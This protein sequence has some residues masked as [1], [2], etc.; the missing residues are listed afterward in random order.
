MRDLADRR[1]GRLILVTS[2]N[3]FHEDTQIEPVTVDRRQRAALLASGGTAEALA[4][5]ESTN[6]A[7]NIWDSAGTTRLRDPK[8]YT[9][10]NTY[11]TQGLVYEAY[12]DLYL[13]I[14]RNAT[15]IPIFKESFESFQQ[16][17]T[18]AITLNENA[19]VS[20]TPNPGNGGKKSLELRL[21]TAAPHPRMSI[22]VEGAHVY[23][24]LIIDFKFYPQGTES[25]EPLV[26]GCFDAN[27][28]LWGQMGSTST[29][30]F[31]MNYLTHGE[32][33][34]GV[35]E[36]NIRDARRGDT[37]VVEFAFNPAAAD[38]SL[39]LDDISITGLK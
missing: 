36:C 3:E 21:K 25:G 2:F 32:F 13:N 38:H 7:W 19:F 27:S 39:L 26:V 6:Q 35:I 8:Q 33:H 12:N 23:N 11:L 15:T 5:Q 22:I 28:E 30:E 1:A 24:F 29:F 18:P 4:N 10:P 37:V 9:G 16:T 14:L 17:P 34:Y 31:G 20:D